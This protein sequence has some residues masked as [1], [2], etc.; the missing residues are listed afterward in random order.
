MN[1]ILSSAFYVIDLITLNIQEISATCN[2][3]QQSFW[4]GPLETFPTAPPSHSKKKYK[5]KLY[6]KFKWF[7]CIAGEP[8][9]LAFQNLRR[10]CMGKPDC[11]T[12]KFCDQSGASLHVVYHCIEGTYC[13]TCH[14]YIL[15]HLDLRM[16]PGLLVQLALLHP[17]HICSYNM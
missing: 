16:Q 12:K 10:M 17:R 5:I 3:K 15:S 6:F 14:R 7:I 1:Q 9:A 8:S 4:S 13:H 2:T 11:P